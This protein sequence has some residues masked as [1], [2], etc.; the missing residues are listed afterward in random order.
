MLIFTGTFP[1]FC[2]TFTKCNDSHFPHDSATV[3]NSTRMNIKYSTSV[4]TAGDSD[5]MKV[6]CKF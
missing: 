3:V 4:L 5:E 2:L 6:E 1:M